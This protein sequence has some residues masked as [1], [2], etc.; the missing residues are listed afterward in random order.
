VNLVPLQLGQ[1]HWTHRWYSTGK[2]GKL[3]SR[4]EFWNIYFQTS[5]VLDRNLSLLPSE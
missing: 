3:R 1:A 5:T 4:D 2:G